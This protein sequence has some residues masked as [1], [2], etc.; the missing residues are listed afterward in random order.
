MTVDLGGNGRWGCNREVEKK[1]C[2]WMLAIRNGGEINGGDVIGGEIEGLV[3]SDWS[4]SAIERWPLD[5]KPDQ[6]FTLNRR[7]RRGAAK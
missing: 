7:G 2:D 5:P 6:R 4:G 3:I 1:I